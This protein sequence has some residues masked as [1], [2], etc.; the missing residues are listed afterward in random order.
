MRHKHTAMKKIILF[1]PLLFVLLSCQK[2]ENNGLTINSVMISENTECHSDSFNTYSINIKL[3]NNGVDTIR[4][5][6]MT[7]GKTLNF[8]F[9]RNDIYFY[10]ECI[11]STPIEIALAPEQEY[12]LEGCISAKN[13]LNQKE[14]KNI[15]IG[16][17][18]YDIR[19]F[20]ELDYIKGIFTESGN[21]LL[22]ENVSKSYPDTIWYK[23]KIKFLRKIN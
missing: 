11:R 9:K 19:K 22:P 2:T 18:F 21:T 10:D 14:M 6:S 20:T 7:C 17:K 23:K 5:W 16:F 1:I 15:C 3:K 12:K 13:K 4:L 8:I